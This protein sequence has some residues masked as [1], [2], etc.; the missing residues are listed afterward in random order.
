MSVVQCREVTELS[1]MK[2]WETDC[3]EYV[4]VTVQMHCATVLFQPYH[5][6]IGM[7]LGCET[8]EGSAE[9]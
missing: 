7:V 5:V 6:D 8:S 3:S 4:Y 1:G 9:V 2:K